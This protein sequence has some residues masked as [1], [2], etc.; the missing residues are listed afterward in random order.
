M[1]QAVFLRLLNSAWNWRSLNLKYSMLRK[2]VQ[3][4]SSEFFE[5]NN[6]T[7]VLITENLGRLSDYQGLT[8][9]LKSCGS[10]VSYCLRNLMT[11][12]VPFL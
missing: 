1:L 11:V 7:Q 3:G 5:H 12:W 2:F 6:E 10:Q 8:V 4:S 9:I